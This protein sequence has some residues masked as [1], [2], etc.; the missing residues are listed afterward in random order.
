M[1]DRTTLLKIPVKFVARDISLH[2]ELSRDF[3]ILILISTD[4]YTHS[5]NDESFQSHHLHKLVIHHDS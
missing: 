4:Y 1:V 2:T 5:Q 3:E